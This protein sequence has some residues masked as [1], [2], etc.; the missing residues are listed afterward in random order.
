[1]VQRLDIT[2]K[3]T[4]NASNT[5][6]QIRTVTH[7]T[8]TPILTIVRIGVRVGRMKW[9][10]FYHPDLSLPV[11][12][13]RVGDELLDL[14]FGLGELA[15]TRGWSAISPDERERATYYSAVYRLKKKGLVVSKGDH[16]RR[17]VFALTETGEAY[18]SIIR[19]PEKAWNR[20]WGG[21]WYV[22]LYDVPETK[23]A[24]RNTLRVFLKR[25]RMGCLQ[26]SVWVTP[27]D[28]RPEYSDLVEGAQVDKYAHLLEARTVLGQSSLEVVRMAWDFEAL[29]LSQ[30]RYCEVFRKN[31][32]HLKK[33]DVEPSELM[34]LAREEGEAYYAVMEQDPLLPRT[35]WLSGY[36][37]E[38]VYRIHRQML[39]AI[40]KKLKE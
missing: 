9:E 32:F 4:N 19:R 20:K 40:R 24:Y 15:L 26:K 8:L 11:V 37:G 13:R 29:G 35:L 23:R 5:V 17:P 25:M 14:F 16:F 39:Q 21:R 27:S 10:K 3:T 6:F 31:L 33:G 18:S 7:T 1:M 34:R 28:I 2:A 30:S 22:L 12:R 36:L 38:K